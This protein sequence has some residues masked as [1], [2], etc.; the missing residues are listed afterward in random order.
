VGLIV[1]AS[2]QTVAGLLI[3]TALFAF[4]VAFIAPALLSLTVSRVPLE[5]RGTVVGTATLFLDVSF[6]IAPVVLG[7]VAE[8]GGYS[9]GF[10]VAGL[11]SAV[12]CILLIGGSSP[13]G[14]VRSRA[15]TLG[16]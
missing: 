8:V 11:V 9:L 16:T 5:E 4:G 6:G 13:R 10:L 15:A 7:A 2:I 12:G 1:V 3:G 14:P